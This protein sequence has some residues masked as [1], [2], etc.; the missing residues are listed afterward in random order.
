MLLMVRSD[1]GMK[2]GKKIAQAGHGVGGLYRQ[3]MDGCLTE[4]QE[5]WFE[6]WERNGMAKIT[7]RTPSEEDFNLVA[8]KAQELNVPMTLVVDAGLTQVPPNSKTVLALGPA[9]SYI[10]DELCGNYKLM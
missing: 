2:P 4:E 8:V 3:Y 9:P 6:A 5:A 1:L 7:I 10:T